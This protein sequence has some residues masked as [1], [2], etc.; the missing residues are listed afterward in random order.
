MITNEHYYRALNIMDRIEEVRELKGI[1]KTVI[2]K[3]LNHTEPYYHAAFN[4]S[5]IIRIDT[6]MKYAR[7]LDVSVAYLL[8]NGKMDT[9]KEFE[10]NYDNIINR[11]TKKLPLRLRALRSQLKKYKDKHLTVK[12]LFEFEHYYKIP[13]IQL[14]G[15][16]ECTSIKN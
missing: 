1:S 7:V 13:A 16:E 10:I 12:S 8:S 6:L 4:F 5:R 3:S 15:G 2:G 14:I 9:F 11:H